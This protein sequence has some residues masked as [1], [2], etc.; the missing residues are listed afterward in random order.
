[1]DSG[2]VADRPPVI[3]SVSVTVQLALPNMLAAGVKVRRPVVF[4][5]GATA[6]SAVAELQ[7]TV[8][9][10]GSDSLGP[11]EMLVAHAALYAPESSATVT[12]PPAVKEGGSFTA[13]RRTRAQC[14][15]SRHKVC[16]SWNA[17]M[18]VNMMHTK[19]V[20]EVSAHHVS[21][22]IPCSATTRDVQCSLRCNSCYAQSCSGVPDMSGTYQTLVQQ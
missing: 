20:A 17:G 13:E 2:A 8:N 19:D 1:M 21:R 18:H 12:V 14:T 16:V 4:S 11:E 9:A 6:N 7:L 22:I 5:A 3:C 10:S 15:H